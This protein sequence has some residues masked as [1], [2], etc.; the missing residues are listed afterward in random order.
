MSALV[1]ARTAWLT[2]A[3]AVLV[4]GMVWLGLWQYGAYDDRQHDDSAAAVAR[5]PV[6]LDE[7]LGP[8]APFPTASVSQPVTV[9][10]RYLPAEQFYVTGMAGADGDYAVVTPTLT[11]TG[12][13]ILV[14][15]GFSA[16][17]D[18]EPPSGDVSVEGVLEPS[19][20]AASALDSTRTTDGI[21]IARLVQ[22][23]DEDLY[24]GYVIA[25]ASDPRDALRPVPVPRPEASFW[26][27]IRN[28]LYALQWWAFAAFAVF[29]WW[30]A[31]RE[32]GPED[33]ASE[34]ADGVV[35]SGSPDGRGA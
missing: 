7:A 18:A 24:A 30:R 1:R 6:P 31:V 33:P 11:E 3:A 13:A 25:T 10:G 22:S 14:V 27:G 9:A 23:F 32:P 21:Q 17:P 26:A 4:A 16:A 34:G 12:S 19:Q 15:R 8:D 28:L 2:I 29:M 20:D 35:A 5:P